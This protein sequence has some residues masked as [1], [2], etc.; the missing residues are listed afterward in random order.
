MIRMRISKNEDGE[1]L[2]LA[3]DYK[4]ANEFKEIVALKF[5]I[6]SSIAVNRVAWL[7]EVDGEWEASTNLDREAKQFYVG[8]VAQPKGKSKKKSKKAV[9]TKDLPEYVE[10][11]GAVEDLITQPVIATSNENGESSEMAVDIELT[12]PDSKF[13]YVD[14]DQQYAPVDDE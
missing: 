13:E 9:E 10:G 7:K 12:S 4:N 8:T 1:F 3:S 2:G 6:T 5:S 14:N 11:V